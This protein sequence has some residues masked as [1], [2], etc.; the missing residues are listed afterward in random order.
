MTPPYL[1]NCTEFKQSDSYKIDLEDLQPQ[2]TSLV[3]GCYCT[4]GNSG[5][6]VTFEIKDKEII[7]YYRYSSCGGWLIYQWYHPKY[8][9]PDTRTT[10]GTLPIEILEEN[11]KLCKDLVPVGI[12]INC[13]ATYYLSV[14]DTSD[15][16]VSNLQEV[17]D[18]RILAQIQL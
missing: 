5:G 3:D 7:R 2:I 17:E 14:D 12:T 10:E 9:S 13:K 6:W 16:A 4:Q 11:Q 18:K 8:F 1:T 15:G